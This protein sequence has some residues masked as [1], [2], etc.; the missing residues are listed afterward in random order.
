LTHR[1]LREKTSCWGTRSRYTCGFISH[2]NHVTSPCV[3]G[4]RANS[5]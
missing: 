4:K 5:I 2:T 1:K 3:A